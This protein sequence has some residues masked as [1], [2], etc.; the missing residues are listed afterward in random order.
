MRYVMAVAA[1]VVVG[2]AALLIST[3]AGRSGVARQ[4]G[5]APAQE[6]NPELEA[7]ATELAYATAV[8]EAD[9]VRTSA[10]GRMRPEQKLATERA[11]AIGFTQGEADLRGENALELIEARKMTYAEA[12]AVLGQEQGEAPDTP[13]D[14]DLV[15][16]VRMRGM[17]SLPPRPAA[18]PEPVTGTW[19]T[20]CRVL[21]GTSIDPVLIGFTP[22][23]TTGAPSP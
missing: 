21:R 8:A 1:L 15:W 13:A 23:P 2:L 10:Y 9:V 22:D 7:R 20:M 17:V 11:A 19:Y 16:L 14:G 12:V 18:E 6:A 3:N 4:P 5:A